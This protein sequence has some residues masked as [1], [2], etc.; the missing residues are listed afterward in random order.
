VLYKGISVEVRLQPEVTEDRLEASRA[1]F[2]KGS[3]HGG[4]TVLVLGAG[5]LSAI[6]PMDLITKLFNEGKVC[7]LKLSPVN[8]HLGPWLEDA[9]SEAVRRGVLCFTYGGADE[10]AYLAGHPGIDEIHLTGSDRTYDAMVW[11]PPASARPEG[12]ESTA[13]YKA[14]NRR[15]GKRV[16]RSGGARALSR[17][18]A[19][20]PGPQHRGWC[21]RTT[22][23]STVTP[24]GC[25]SPRAAGKQRGALLNSI[26][27]ALGEA[28]VRK[29][30]YPGAE[31]RY[32]TFTQGRKGLRSVGSAATGE[33]PWTLMPGLDP[34]DPR[35]I[36]FTTESFCPRTIRD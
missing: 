34:T 27:R 36:A 9:F 22:C 18:R 11:G 19:G 23:R 13:D 10:G 25:S 20:L 8:D 15:V 12:A 30:Y 32:Q 33:L 24:P 17:S 6:A 26:E 28:P 14:D 1:S 4:R 21:S 35:E 31:N 2:Y 29:A 3:V 7:L 5:N 16:P